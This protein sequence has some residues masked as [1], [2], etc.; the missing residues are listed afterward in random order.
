MGRAWGG[1]HWK[2]RAPLYSGQR[3]HSA[4]LSLDGNGS[5]GE[6]PAKIRRERLASVTRREESVSGGW[7]FFY[8]E[9]SRQSHLHNW[10]AG[11]ALR[12]WNLG[13]SKGMELNVSPC[14]LRQGLRNC[15]LQ[16]LKS[17]LH[18]GSQMCSQRPPFTL[19]EHL[20]IP[21]RLGGFDY[22]EGKLVAG[23]RQIRCV[24]AGDLQKY[25]GIRAAFVGLTSGVQE[26]RTEPQAGRH[27]LFVA[28]RMADGLQ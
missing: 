20:K 14:R 9:R 2:P 23:Y 19:R 17:C 4:G 3:H 16:G 7:K 15:F 10:G 5:H 21:T 25:S 22:V 13:T 27:A 12:G 11:L 24:I 18:I 28:H 26:T 8:D 1:R 6:G